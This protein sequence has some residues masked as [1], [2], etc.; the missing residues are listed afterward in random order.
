MVCRDCCRMEGVIGERIEARILL[1]PIRQD[2][3][4]LIVRV[5]VND[6]GLL[7]DIPQQQPHAI[8]SPGFVE[9]ID[10]TLAEEGHER[11]GAELE[12][13][14]LPE[15]IGP[16]GQRDKECHD[17]DDGQKRC[18][19]QLRLQPHGRPRDSCGPVDHRRPA[20][21]LVE[22]EAV[23]RSHAPQGSPVV[24]RGDAHPSLR[25]CGFN[26]LRSFCRGA[27]PRMLNCRRTEA[28]VA[29]A[30]RVGGPP[31]IWARSCLR[32]IRPRGSVITITARL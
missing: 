8:Q 13:A 18:Q 22:G 20:P 14:P 32:W 6:V 30:A 28:G 24:P 26:F 7:Q 12:R 10:D 9:Y 19:R 16:N 1:G 23:T 31:L 4:G 11:S 15:F 2:L 25:H 5:G 21:S 29:G 17:D 27:V 3:P